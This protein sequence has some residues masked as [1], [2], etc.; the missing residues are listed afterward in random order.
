[1]FRRDGR[2]LAQNHHETG[3]YRRL[4]SVYSG[5]SANANAFPTF[6]HAPKPRLERP[7]DTDNAGFDGGSGKPRRD[8]NPFGGNKPVRCL[9]LP[10]PD[11]SL[12]GPAILPAVGF[13]SPKSGALVSYLRTN[14]QA[15]SYGRTGGVAAPLPLENSFSSPKPGGTRV[16]QSSRLVA[17]RSA[18]THEKNNRLLCGER[19]V[20]RR[21]RWLVDR[22]SNHAPLACRGPGTEWP[23]PPVGSVGQ[24][25]LG[26]Q[27]V[28]HPR[29][30]HQHPRLRR[31]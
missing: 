31:C 6:P 17:N 14:T 19:P 22:E 5:R 21:R 13:V 8:A 27:P 9:G 4:F 1:L 30:T 25:F 18:V 11:C 15:I 28:A 12:L 3:Q 23:G 10:Q 20:W 24:R 29:R 7:C 2:L 16:P 26:P